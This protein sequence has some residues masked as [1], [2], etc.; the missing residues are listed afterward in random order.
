MST[1]TV[2]GYETIKEL[3]SEL[4]VGIGITDVLALSEDNDPFFAGRPAAVAD[5]QWFLDVWQ[6]FG[7][8]RGVHLRRIHYRLVTEGNICETGSRKNKSGFGGRAPCQRCWSEGGTL[9]LT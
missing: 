6:R 8:G 1:G 4:C 9:F 3:A 5:A 2:G 7:F